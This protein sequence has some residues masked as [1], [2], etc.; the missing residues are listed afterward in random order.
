MCC[1]VVHKRCHEF[2]TFSC[3]GADKGPASDVSMTHKQA[4]VCVN[5]CVC[6][7]HEENS[8]KCG[9]FTHLGY[10]DVKTLFFFPPPVH[11][12]LSSTG[13]LKS[14]VLCLCDFRLR[15]SESEH[16]IMNFN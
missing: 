13:K 3:P 15:D 7:V 5:L 16:R 11:L 14:Q 6:P 1:F 4:R 2:V 9:L 12:V 10:V 8:K